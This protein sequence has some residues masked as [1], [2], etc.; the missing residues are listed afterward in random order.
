[1]T[2]Q[3]DQVFQTPAGKYL[4]DTYEDW[5]RGEG[6]PVHKGVA[7]DMFAVETRPWARFGVDGAMCHLD[8]RDDFLTVFVFD[9]APG[10]SSAPIKHLYEEV[11]YV[12]SG[13][14]TADI[15]LPGGAKKTIEFSPKALF[16]APMNASIRLRNTSGGQAR[17]AAVNDFRYLIQL[18][19]NETFLFDNPLEFPDRCDGNFVRNCLE[20]KAGVMSRPNELITPIS[21]AGGS[22]GCDLVEIAGGK[23]ARARRQMFGSLLLGVAGEGMTLTWEDDAGEARKTLWRHG[24][25]FAPPG[26]AFNQHCNVGGGAARYLAIELGSIN[27]PMFRPRRKNYGDAAVYAAGDAVVEFDAQNPAVDFA[28]RAA[29]MR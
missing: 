5:A 11:Y 18:Y 23:Y 12:L 7:I 10:E 14:A 6:V 26:M 2:S 16:A 1:M 29:T 22:I 4:V 20:T 24:V 8:G 17:I 9:L 27:G 25:A 28:F 15:E 19:R 21:L 3:V 13:T